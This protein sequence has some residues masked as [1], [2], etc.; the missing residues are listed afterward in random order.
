MAPLI[1]PIGKPVSLGEGPFWDADSQSLYFVDIVGGTIHK[2][3]NQTKKQF[4]AK[5]GKLKNYRIILS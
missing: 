1:E 5:V 3:N 4:S 2:Y